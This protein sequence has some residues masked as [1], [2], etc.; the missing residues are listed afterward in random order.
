MCDTFL[1]QPHNITGDQ[2]IPATTNAVAFNSVVHCSSDNGA[3][4]GIHT[5]GVTAGGK[6]TDSFDSHNNNL[7]LSKTDCVYFTGSDEKSKATFY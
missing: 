3:D 7:Q 4:A 2:T 1:I 5:G 6:Y